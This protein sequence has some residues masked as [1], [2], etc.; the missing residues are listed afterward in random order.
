MIVTTTNFIE[1][2]QITGYH[3]IVTG[4]TI[5]GANI[6]RDFLARIR[7]IVGGRAG[8]YEKVLRNARAKAIKEMYE[9]AR[10]R[11]GNAVIGV[12]LDYG[13]LGLGGSM[14]TVSAS[15]TAVTIA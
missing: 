9:E 12:R 14:L 15:G 3:G 1:G 5:M 13:A 10:Q 7:N 4:E 11:G 8:S 6:F 2:K